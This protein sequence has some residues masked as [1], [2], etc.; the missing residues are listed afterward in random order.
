MNNDDIIIIHENAHRDA[1][2]MILIIM[3]MMTMTFNLISLFFSSFVLSY[4]FF[5]PGCNAFPEFEQPRATLRADSAG[6]FVT[7]L[8]WSAIHHRLLLLSA[9]SAFLTRHSFIDL[10]AH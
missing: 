2:T 4:F 6:L 7:G 3:A 10:L 8:F 9:G 1:V 5:S